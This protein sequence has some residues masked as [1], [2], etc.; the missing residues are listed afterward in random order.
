MHHFLLANYK[1]ITKT[2]LKQN[3]SEA[4]N[5]PVTGLKIFRNGFQFGIEME[6]SVEWNRV[7]Q[8]IEEQNLVALQSITE[9]VLQSTEEISTAEYS[10]A[11]KSIVEQSTV[12]QCCTVTQSA[13]LWS[14][15]LQSGKL[16]TITEQSIIEWSTVEYRRVENRGAFS[17]G[18]RESVVEHCGVS[19][20]EWRM[21]EHC[22]ALQSRVLQSGVLLSGELESIVEYC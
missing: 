16:W 10:I 8:S 3:D 19:I 13:V 5:D 2:Y 4:L 14:G 11:E 22:G 7:W 9:Y 18:E 1:I 6:S 15:A 21:G 17:S 12:K 20:V